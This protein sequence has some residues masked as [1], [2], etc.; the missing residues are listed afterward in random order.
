MRYAD[1]RGVLP[2]PVVESFCSHTSYSCNAGLNLPV[3]QPAGSSFVMLC[4][5]CCSVR[6]WFAAVLV[7]CFVGLYSYQKW[8]ACSGQPQM[9]D[10]EVGV[11]ETISIACEQ[12]S[13]K[14][15]VSEVTHTQSLHLHNDI[16]MLMQAFASMTGRSYYQLG[17]LH[18]C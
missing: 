11:G 14:L 1:T 16:S 4:D 7:D 6:K 2:V 13:S 15:V 10:C 18:Q 12:V 8:Q 9:E 3:A 5:V 17:P